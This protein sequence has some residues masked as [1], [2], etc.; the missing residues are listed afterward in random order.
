MICRREGPEMSI[1]AKRHCSRFLI[2]CFESAGLLLTLA[3]ILVCFA[4]LFAAG[5]VM[6][7]Q[8]LRSDGLPFARLATGI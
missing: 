5:S 2:V 7:E 1:A 6:F 3:V 4:L 8:W